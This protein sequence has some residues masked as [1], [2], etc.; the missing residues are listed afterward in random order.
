MRGFAA[1]LALA[2]AAFSLK[3]AID[4]PNGLSVAKAGVDAASAVQRMS[5]LL[6]S[7]G[8]EN[9]VIRGARG[10]WKLALRTGVKIGAAELLALAS[11]MIEG[12]KT[13]RHLSK[14]E[15]GDAAF[16]AGIAVGGAISMLPVFIQTGSMA[17]PIGIAIMTAALIGQ[18]VWQNAKHIHEGE[19]DVRKGLVLLGYKPGHAD[20]LSRRGKYG[21]GEASGKGQMQALMNWARSQGITADDLRA[22][23]NGL[24]REQVMRLSKAVLHGI[25]VGNGNLLYGP[26]DARKLPP[27]IIPPGTLAGSASFRRQMAKD[28]EA[29]LVRADVPL[30]YSGGAVI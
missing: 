3:A 22:W 21:S 23:V 2:G 10:G 17:G 8:V 25:G 11:T 29:D 9:S 16:S 20:I 7:L 14:G 5:D 28:F 30:P 13:I 6:R 26:E 18:M 1:A 12:A 27:H 24:T 19:D 15:I 4:D